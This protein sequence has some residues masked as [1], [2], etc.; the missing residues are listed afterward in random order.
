M[1]RKMKLGGLLGLAAAGAAAW[2]FLGNWRPANPNMLPA[3]SMDQLN[4]PGVQSASAETLA[5]LKAQGSVP[6][7]AVD[8]YLVPGLPG[9]HAA[10]PPGVYAVPADLAAGGES[11]LPAIFSGMGR[12]ATPLAV[13]GRGGFPAQFRG[14]GRNL[15]TQETPSM[16]APKSLGGGMATFGQP[17]SWKAGQLYQP[18]TH[19]TNNGTTG[20]WF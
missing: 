9:L 5:G 20:L 3:L 4:G 2:Y 17:V 1:A 14:L 11:G 8:V 18:G 13:S 16:Q 6:A 7:D 12:R 19:D 15:T 10:G